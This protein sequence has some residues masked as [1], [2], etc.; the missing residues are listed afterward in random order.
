M[1]MTIALLIAGMSLPGSGLAAAPAANG[2]SAGLTAANGT[3]AGLTAANDAAPVEPSA[4]GTARAGT[5]TPPTTTPTTTVPARLI[6]NNP[7]GTAADRRALLNHVVSSIQRQQRGDVIRILTYQIHD[8]AVTK[9]LVQAH[10]SGVDVRIVM[11]DTAFRKGAHERRLRTVLGT[12]TGA[13]SFIVA[14]YRQSMHIKMYSFSNGSEVS[15]GSSNLTNWRHWNHLVR[16]TSPALHRKVSDRFAVMADGQ[17]YGYHRITHRNVRLDLFPGKA[18]PVR[19][20]IDA[21]HGENIHVQMFTWG[22]SR[23]EAMSEALLAAQRR[24]CRTRVIANTGVPWTEAVRLVAGAGADVFNTRLVTNGRGYPHDKLVVIGDVSLTGSDNWKHSHRRHFETVARIA[25][26]VLAQR[27][28]AY[29]MRTREQ[30][31]GGP[32]AAPLPG[33][34]VEPTP[35]GLAVSWAPRPGAWPAGTFHEVRVTGPGSGSSCTVAYRRVAASS[36]ADPR[37]GRST[38]TVPGL[39]FSTAY[40]VSVTT[41]LPGGNRSTAAVAT[42][43]T[44]D[45][46][47]GPPSVDRLEATSPTSAVVRLLPTQRPTSPPPVSFQVSTRDA[48]GRWSPASPSP[49]RLQLDRLPSDQVTLIRARSV[50][51]VG[52]HSRWSEAHRVVPTSAPSEPRALRLSTGIRKSLALAWRAPRNTGIGGVDQWRVRHRPAGAAGGWTTVRLTDPTARRIPL[53]DVG[54]SGPARVRMAAANET[55]RSAFSAPIDV[56]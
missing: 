32:P 31:R 30:A 23:G 7:L 22:S 6:T 34:E 8:D 4:T 5:T 18:D 17:G 56:G 54:I 48:N 47:P 40:G 52:R 46:R 2:T 49:R 38:T 26:P 11:N 29:V 27:M 12:D 16:L 36:P 9:A 24:S 41:V 37:T 10:R 15:V 53:A 51:E 44:Y 19:D 20:A 33:V 45:Q 25:D 35:G 21:A 42:A 43:A 1:R 3:S 55:G 28:R 13:R 50:P 39:D 14:P